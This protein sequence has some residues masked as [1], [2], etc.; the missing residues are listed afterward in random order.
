MSN[1]KDFS[2]RNRKKRE[3]RR[4]R[5]MWMSVITANITHEKPL[6]APLCIDPSRSLLKHVQSIRAW[7]YVS[8]DRWI[9]CGKFR[10]SSTVCLIP[11]WDLISEI[12]ANKWIRIAKSKYLT[13]LFYRARSHQRQKS[14]W[15]YSER[16][17][18]IWNSHNSHSWLCFIKK[19][20]GIKKQGWW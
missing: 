12:P 7:Y 5:E 17:D 4:V 20:K 13:S 6:G 11:I 2:R 19:G 18:G 1:S 8:S 10:K 9:M 15:I 14:T 3:R 16:L